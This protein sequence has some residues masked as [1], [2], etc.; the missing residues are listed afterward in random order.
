[1]KR[2]GQRGNA[3]RTHDGMQEERRKNAEGTQES[4][5]RRRNAAGTQDRMQEERRNKHDSQKRHEMLHAET[6]RRRNAGRNVAGTQLQE[7]L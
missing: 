7:Q 2:C 3:G 4:Y 5:R 6:E 1:M